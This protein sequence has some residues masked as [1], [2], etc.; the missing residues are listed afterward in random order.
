M[1]SFNGYAASSDAQRALT[2]NALLDAVERGSYAFWNAV[3]DA[4]ADVGIHGGDV[5]PYDD[6]AHTNANYAAVWAWVGGADISDAARRRLCGLP[7][8]DRASVVA[9]LSSDG[10]REDSWFILY[11]DGSR[12]AGE[13]T[14]WSDAHDYLRANGYR[15]VPG[16]ADYWTRVPD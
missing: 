12:D 3:A 11:D 13:F 14:S 15:P 6:Y 16:Q 4:L 1:D 2:P 9:E 5:L 7:A 8:A 10:S